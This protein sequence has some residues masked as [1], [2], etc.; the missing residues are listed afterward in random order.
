MQT[1][2]L[3]NAIITLKSRIKDLLT[4]FNNDTG[5]TVGSVLAEAKYAT[6]KSANGPKQILSEYE[7]GINIEL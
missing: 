7:I 6:L 2:E 1:N 5:L 4:Q 3:P